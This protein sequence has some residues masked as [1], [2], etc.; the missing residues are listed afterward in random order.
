VVKYVYD[1]WGNFKV[2][3]ITG[4][5]ITDETHLGFL[6]PFR[7][8]SYY[9]DVETNLYYL[10]SRYYDPEICRFITIDDISYLDPDS[11]NGLNLY[12]YC[13]NNPVMMIDNSG[14][15]PAW[16]QWLL[17]GI[18]VALV[19]VAAGM[20]IFGTGGVAAFGVGALIGS[21]SVGTVGAGVGAAIG[22]ATSGIDGILGGALA[23]FGIGA[24]VGFV[25]GGTIGHSAYLRST[26]TV[27]GK[28][29][30][31]YRGGNSMKLKTNEYK[32]LSDGSKRG[33]SVNISPSQVQN[34]GGSYR[35]TKVPRGLKIVQQGKNLNHFEIIPNKALTVEK[36][37]SF[38]NKIKLVKF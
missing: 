2:Y 37:Q 6:N 14:C 21:L 35:V 24:I 38:L 9:Y 18:G 33:I 17:F 1:A 23:G 7:Y 29:V 3:D 25:V 32:I 12:A 11:I 8:R 10:K 20:A 31:V 36:F 28:R 5:E 16:W 27:N 22:Y 30:P 19:T 4:S 13:L 26:V 15:A 34:F